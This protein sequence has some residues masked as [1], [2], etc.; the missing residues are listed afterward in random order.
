MFDLLY[1]IT[2]HII[3]LRERKLIQTLLL[4]KH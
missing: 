1:M 4:Q 2:F 3:K